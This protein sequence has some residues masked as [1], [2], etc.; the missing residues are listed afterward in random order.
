MKQQRKHFLFPVLTWLVLVC[1][2]ATMMIPA[3]AIAQ[4]AFNLPKPGTLITATHPYQPATLTGLTIH[5]DNPLQFEFMIS[6]GDSALTDPQLKNESARLIKYFLASLTIPDNELWVNLAPQEQDRITSKG[7]GETEM[8]RDLLEQDYL[9]KQLTASLMYPEE[10]LGQAFWNRVYE[11]A[12]QQYGITNIPTDLFH[13]VWVVPKNA[14]IYESANSAFVLESHLQ[15]M[16]DEDYQ[17]SRPAAP[18]TENSAQPPAQWTTDMIREILL[19]EIE[20]EVNEGKNFAPLRQIYHSLILAAWYKM[21]LKESLLG[22]VYFDQNKTKGIDLAD[23]EI[24]RKIYDQYMKA[25]EQGVYNYVREDVDPDTQQKTPRQYF[26][27]GLVGLDRNDLR[28]LKGDPA[29][30]SPADQ[31]MISRFTT[32]RAQTYQATVNLVDLGQQADWPAINQPD[33]DE[34]VIS[35]QEILG[36]LD[37]LKPG[38]LESA[39]EEVR[40]KLIIYGEEVVQ[41]V[42]NRYYETPSFADAYRSEL[43]QLLARIGGEAVV[44][45]FLAVI[46]EYL[47]TPAD[48]VIV[49]Q[50]FQDSL[51]VK[52]ILQLLPSL[53]RREIT[54]NHSSIMHMLGWI[55][56]MPAQTNYYVVEAAV[57]TIGALSS[58]GDTRVM[59]A[60]I[61]LLTSEF[62]AEMEMDVQVQLQTKIFDAIYAAGN[63]TT[64]D[65]LIKKLD[66]LNPYE[67]YEIFDAHGSILRYRQP[68]KAIEQ[69]LAFEHE[70]KGQEQLVNPMYQGLQEFIVR[71]QVKLRSQRKYQK[72]DVNHI[73]DRR[74]VSFLKFLK[75]NGL[76]D[77]IV[78]GGGVRDAFLG[79]TLNDIDIAVKMT[80]TPEERRALLETT[81]QANERIY[82]YAFSRLKKLADLLGVEAERFLPPLGEQ[83]IYWSGIE[84]QYAGPIKLADEAGET[85][86]LKRSIF[87]ADTKEVYISITGASLQQLGI[88]ADGN[89]YGNTD[90]LEDL[91]QGVLRVHGDGE[92]FVIGSI[93]RM[94]R[95]KHQL[96]A[97]ILESDYELITANLD[98]YK[99]GELPIVEAIALKAKEIIDKTVEKARDPVF[100]DR[101][102][103]ELGV[104]DLF[105]IKDEI[106]RGVV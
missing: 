88:D 3:E 104:Y 83:G 17:R 61:D 47:E 55:L 62:M 79:R 11:K 36:M 16:L 27:G 86:Y 76:E 38:G 87:D 22:E 37:A 8:G 67:K 46:Y 23:K 50:R 73:R 45:F 31:A 28:V 20:R 56:S 5:P 14:V 93:L 95:L 29:L 99:N 98:K 65:L 85:H 90:A 70:S 35:E 72:L 19:P 41:T 75:D 4:T 57:E 81:A 48:S 97:D 59:P 21:N 34:A 82:E 105:G 24:S 71:F 101:E 26:S 69:Q 84:I 6:A 10:E 64:L 42:F 25:F 66:E 39:K 89:L 30:F 54:D 18:Q 103:K 43:I 12:R 74:L 100:A 7:L 63:M 44:K 1:F 96:N 13:K 68:Q 53:G 33:K 94:L 106:P 92:N 58:H 51:I 80:L 2:S 91:E 49:P 102:L 15:V 9:L 52:Q 78:M 77:I 32:K 60:M 40:E